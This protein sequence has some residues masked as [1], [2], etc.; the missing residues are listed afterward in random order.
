[1][2]NKNGDRWAAI[3]YIRYVLGFLEGISY[4]KTSECTCISQ[5]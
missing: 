2:Q 5:M 4:T 1:M 3:Y